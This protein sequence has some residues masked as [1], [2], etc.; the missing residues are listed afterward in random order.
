MEKKIIN[1]LKQNNIVLDKP[2]IVGVSGGADSVCL[3]SILNKLGY[4][5]VLAHVNHHKR[6]ESE[7]EA[8]AMEDLAKRLNINYYDHNLLEKVS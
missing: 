6:K 5:V 2:I 7:E 8:I 4:K 1:F 3:L